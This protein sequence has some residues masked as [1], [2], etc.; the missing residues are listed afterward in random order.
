MKNLEI[1]FGL[2]CERPSISMRRLNRVPHPRYAD[3]CF[4]SAIGVA[5]I[6]VPFYVYVLI[7][8]IWLC[9]HIFIIAVA[10]HI[11]KNDGFLYC[12]PYT[13]F[14]RLFLRDLLHLLLYLTIYIYPP[15]VVIPCL[16]LCSVCYV[17]P[18]AACRRLCGGMHHVCMFP[19]KIT[20][21]YS[22]RQCCAVLFIYK[23]F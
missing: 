7:Y 9:S 3:S 19:Y 23:P 2:L 18:S 20:E 21:Q 12:R 17:L 16:Y 15:F 11:L 10:Y 5:C 4:M 6:G 14:V 8:A 1:I 13:N 22:I